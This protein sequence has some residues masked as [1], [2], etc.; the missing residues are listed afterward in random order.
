MYYLVTYQIHFNNGITISQQL[1]NEVINICP[2]VW[3]TKRRHK[4]PKENY[5]L[6]SVF[7]ITS[8]T[9]KDLAKDAIKNNGG[10]I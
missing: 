8:V 6:I 7:E 3:L 9:G 1:C 2:L 5:T 4:Y 10:E